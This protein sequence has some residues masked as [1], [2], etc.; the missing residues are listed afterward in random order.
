MISKQKEIVNKLVDE[1]FDEITKLDEK[2]NSDD[3]IY[4]NRGPTANAKND[5]ADAKND[6]IKFKSDLSE[7]KKGNKK[8]DQRSKK[9]FV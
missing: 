7:I 2:V 3:L 8:I 6:Q 5:L 4:K 9:H 1:R